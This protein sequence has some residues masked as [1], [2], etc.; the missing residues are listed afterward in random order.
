MCQRL[1]STSHGQEPV[2]GDEGT[3][4]RKTWHCPQKLTAE[5]GHRHTPVITTQGTH[6]VIAG[7]PRKEPT[8]PEGFLGEVA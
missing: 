1:G 8:Q 7:A 6:S 3:E 2:L 5:Q 4:V